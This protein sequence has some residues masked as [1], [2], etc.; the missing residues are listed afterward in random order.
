VNFTGGL[1]A[2]TRDVERKE[3]SML[4]SSTQRPVPVAQQD[5]AAFATLCA[6][7]RAACERAADRT[8]SAAG[9]SARSHDIVQI[10]DAACERAW[11]ER[12]DRPPN[13]SSYG[14]LTWMAQREAIAWQ[15]RQER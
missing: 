6:E 15:Q 5:R 3:A 8:L 13:W 2:G 12:D 9:S 10:V 7:M 4:R 1:H 11:E 14:W